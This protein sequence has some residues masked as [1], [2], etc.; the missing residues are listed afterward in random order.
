MN[1]AILSKGELYH[2]HINEIFR[3]IGDEQLNYNWLITDCV[4]YPKNKA[5]DELF[6][7]EYLW[8]S[9]E[10]LTEI[11]H[12]EDFQ[13]IWGVLSGFAKDVTLEEVLKHDLPF[14]DG[15]EGF[16]VDDVEVQH[17]I[18]DIEIVA[19]DSSLTL[20]ISK[21]D[22]LMNR[23]RT[24]FPLSEDLSAQNKRDNSEILE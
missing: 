13:F 23:F 5:F 3:S 9:G 2:T 6:S 21:R 10:Q 14:A 4:C 1:S 20:F 22:D 19:W 7:K 18:A 16:W 15:Y 11:I 12:E 8:I 24:Y 17:P